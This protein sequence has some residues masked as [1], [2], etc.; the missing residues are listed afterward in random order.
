M[1]LLPLYPTLS[2][3]LLKSEEFKCVCESLTA[4][5]LLSSESIFVNPMSEVEK[6]KMEKCKR[7]FM[8]VEGDLLTLVNVYEKWKDVSMLMFIDSYAVRSM[9]IIRICKCNAPYRLV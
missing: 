3:L 8:V 1:A 4:V 2:H 5:S 9:L 6:E 7:G